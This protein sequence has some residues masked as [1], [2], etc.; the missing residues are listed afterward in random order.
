MKLMEIQNNEKNFV[1]YS[2]GLYAR[3]RLIEGLT[4]NTDDKSG[5]CEWNW[6]LLGLLRCIYFESLCRF[7]ARKNSR[8]IENS[9]GRTICVRF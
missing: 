8:F 3:I 7:F 5:L 4:F 9:I 6:C 1:V 2:I